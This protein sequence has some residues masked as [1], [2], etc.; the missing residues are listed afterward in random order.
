M[1][2]NGQLYALDINPAAVEHVKQKVES[3]GLTNVEVVRADAAKTGLLEESVDVAFLFGVLHSIKDMHSVLLEMHRV[4]K[5]GG[6]L[7]V[8]KSS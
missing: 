5:E 1:G 6:A 4:V 8:Q 7:A 2:K 3:R